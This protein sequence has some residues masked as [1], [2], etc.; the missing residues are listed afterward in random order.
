MNRPGTI[1]G[2][3]AVATAAAVAIAAAAPVPSIAALPLPKI[4]TPKL[5]PLPT[6]PSVPIPTV[7]PV[8]V[9]TVVHAL[10]TV[11][12]TPK[13]PPAPVPSAV[14]SPLQAPTAP[15][16]GQATPGPANG[17][18]GSG[19]VAGSHTT[20]APSGGSSTPGAAPVSPGV[21]G[22]APGTTGQDHQQTVRRQRRQGNRVRH[23]LRELGSCLDEL[24]VDQRRVLILRAGFGRPHPRTPGQVADKLEMSKQRVQRLQRHGLQRLRTAD[25]RQDCSS[26]DLSPLHGTSGSTRAQA[27]ATVEQDLLADTPTA[28]VAADSSSSD[29][30]GVRGESKKSSG[31]GPPPAT[32]RVPPITPPTDSQGGTDVLLVVLLLATAGAA[33]VVRH[34]LR[35]RDRAAPP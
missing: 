34:R 2:T 33:L 16:G 3:L 14:P 25:R 9:P 5:P 19:S 24:P 7:P 13:P 21:S 4:G 31:G 30:S 35:G 10:P 6:L 28:R 17:S 23:A 32:V 26:L 1:R 18:S 11:I 20:P 22:A 12:P 8:P 27:G 15:P 29:M